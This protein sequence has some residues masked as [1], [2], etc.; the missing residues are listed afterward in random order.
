[1]KTLFQVLSVM[2]HAL[3]VMIHLLARISADWFKSLV[4]STG[5]VFENNHIGNQLLSGS[6]SF[7]CTSGLAGVS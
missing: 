5:I 3:S 1:M 2:I 7:I 6:S 4:A